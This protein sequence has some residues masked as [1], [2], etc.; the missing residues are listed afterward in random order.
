MVW[1]CVEAMGTLPAVPA[2]MNVAAGCS[3]QVRSEEGHKI[4]KG[5]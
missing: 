3:V 5:A 4:E 2:M 1:E